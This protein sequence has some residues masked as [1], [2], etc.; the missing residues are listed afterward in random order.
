VLKV[1]DIE[2]LNKCLSEAG[3]MTVSPLKDENIIQFAVT[4]NRTK[5]D[6]DD[7]IKAVEVLS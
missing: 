3:I 6:L 1:K 4:E 7:L 5:D 2:A